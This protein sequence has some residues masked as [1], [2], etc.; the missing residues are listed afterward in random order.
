MLKHTRSMPSVMLVSRVHASVCPGVSYLITDL[1]IRSF[2]C[3][4][5]STPLSGEGGKTEEPPRATLRRPWAHGENDDGPSTT[6]DQ[7]VC[8]SDGQDLRRAL[9]DASHMMHMMLRQV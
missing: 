3:A 9:H 6:L 4:H 7:D 5:I 2:P 1:Q 8:E